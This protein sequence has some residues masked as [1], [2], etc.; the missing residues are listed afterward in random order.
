MWTLQRFLL[1]NCFIQV[2]QRQLNWTLAVTL[3]KDSDCSRGFSYSDLNI[4]QV[5]GACK[6]TERKAKQCP[7]TGLSVML[8]FWLSSSC[9]LGEVS[10]T[11]N[12]VFPAHD[13]SLANK[14]TFKR[15]LSGKS[16]MKK[17]GLQPFSFLLW[18]KFHVW[19]ETWLELGVQET[20]CLSLLVSLRE[21]P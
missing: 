7:A 10:F 16:R 13:L 4:L 18:E 15:F 19:R 14:W 20:E 8:N 17:A 5:T 21:C 2:D 9:S 12:R 3:I 11:I 6:P 1:Q